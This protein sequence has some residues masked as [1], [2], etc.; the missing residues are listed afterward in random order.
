MTGT[1][2]LRAFSSLEPGFSPATTNEVL[3]ETEPLT[4]PPALRTRASAS[5]RESV[6]KVPVTTTVCLVKGPCEGATT[7]RTL[8]CL[9]SRATSATF[10]FSL[11]HVATER[12]MIGPMP[13]TLE[14]VSSLAFPSPASV[15]KRVAPLA[16][17]LSLILLF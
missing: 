6:G 14:S 5:S 15:L 10:P 9:V 2:S 11:N 16:A 7:V 4:F 3:A 8:R 12:P 13:S 1:P 17:V